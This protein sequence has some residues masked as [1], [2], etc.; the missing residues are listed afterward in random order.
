MKKLGYVFFLGI[1]C[2]IILPA[3]SS[4]KE[5][6]PFATFK[7]NPQKTKCLYYRVKS[8]QSNAHINNTKVYHPLMRQKVFVRSFLPIINL[9]CKHYAGYRNFS[10]GQSLAY[11]VLGAQA[12]SEQVGGAKSE[13]NC[14]GHIAFSGKFVDRANCSYRMLEKSAPLNEAKKIYA[15]YLKKIGM[16]PDQIIKAGKEGRKTVV[17]EYCSSGRGLI[18][19]LHMLYD[20]LNKSEKNELNKYVEFFVVY[21]KNDFVKN[22]V[23][24]MQTV[25][26]SSICALCWQDPAFLALTTSDVFKDRLVPQY[27]ANKWCI[28]DPTKY[29]PEK[30]VNS[31]LA[32]VYDHIN[33]LD[34]K[35][36][37]PN[38]DEDLLQ[39][40]ESLS[41]L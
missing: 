12:L 28:V 37:L 39:T 11:L 25:F 5:L 31:V 40:F 32:R 29:A 38:V 22:A 6:L 41:F 2:Q 18:S 7:Q 9:M 36:A 13:F 17:F 24:Y 15:S 14:D 3:S 35:Q 20:D 16:H 30:S 27:Q 23:P 19:F 1:F 21:S 8:T 34:V 26:G 33:N 4:N 10:L